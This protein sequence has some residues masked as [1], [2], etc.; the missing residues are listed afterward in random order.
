[1]AGAY[2]GWSPA[3]GGGV[4]GKSFPVAPAATV[5]ANAASGNGS[6]TIT[7]PNGPS[8]TSLPSF[9]NS[10]TAKV[11]Q[12]L[13]PV[14][15][16]FVP[17]SGTVTVSNRRW[18]ISTD[19]ITFTDITPL[20][21][22]QYTIAASDAGKYLR[23]AEDATDS[24]YGITFG[25]P[26]SLRVTGV[27]AFTA[28]SLTGSA[29]N[30]IV[31]ST[32][33][34]YS[35][36][37]SGY[38]NTFS[39]SAGSLPAGISLDPTTGALS[40][41]ATL[42]GTYNFKVK[43]TNDAGSDETAN[44]T[45]IVGKSPV[46]TSDDS[47]LQ[48]VNRVTNPI[49]VGTAI[50]D[51][52]FTT[53]AYPAATY[54]LKVDNATIPPCQTFALTCASSF[55]T[56]GLPDGLTFDPASATLKGTPTKTGAFVFAIKANN[57]LGSDIEIVHMSIASKAPVAFNL[58]SDKNAV[59]IIQNTTVTAT[60]TAT[61]GS[62]NG[63]Y[64]FFV[65]PT[66][67]AICS[68][69]ASTGNTVT[70]TVLAAGNCVING[71]KAADG[72]FAAAKASITI[73]VNKA[74][75]TSPIAVVADTAPLTFGGGSTWVRATGG[76]GTGAFNWNVDA[77]ST[78]SCGIQGLSGN[79]MLV[80]FTSAGTCVYTVTKAADGFFQA[81]TTQYTI[82]IDKA[83]ITGLYVGNPGASNWNAA[84]PPSV[85][86]ATG[87][88]QGTGAV[89][90]TLDPASAEICTLT[91]NVLQAKSA[92]SCNVSATKAGDINYK[93]MTS[94]SV[95][96]TIYQIAQ[97][98]LTT[99]G[100]STGGTSIAYNSNVPYVAS[101][102]VLVVLTTT[103]GSGT[104][105]YSYTASNASGCVVSGNGAT[106]F[107]TANP[108]GAGVGWCTITV[109]KNGDTNYNPQ[110]TNFQF[111]IPTGPQTPLVATPA[112]TSLDYVPTTLSDPATAAKSQISLTGGLG[113]GAVSYSVAAGSTSVCSV[114]ANGLITD[115]T[116]GTCVINISKAG[117]TNY[118]AQST[119]ATVT[120]NKLNQA[121][122]I[123]T[124]PDSSKPFVWS[125]KA[126]SQITTT[127]GAGTAGQGNN[128]G[129]GS[130]T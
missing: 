126:T 46:F 89:T 96:W 72:G 31:N 20:V 91:G 108:T 1:G 80:G 125:P 95:T 124:S 34:G 93:P 127:G 57:S 81:Q 129:N 25:S 62:G 52:T 116:A 90:Y 11:G 7:W 88:G 107:V 65:D 120:F 39:I 109:T 18:Q 16:I 71:V 74:L 48:S 32:Y 67:T 29:A 38:R 19:G 68:L 35:F 117:D 106:A 50:P 104:G 24:T 28:A 92:G 130:G 101:P 114:D 63:A 33:A 73:P 9:T 118:Q 98:A 78:A 42:T 61:G 70:M 86:L 21:S 110:S 12:V 2:D 41:T 43:V 99:T 84:N 112:S 121:E 5:T 49:R 83:Q 77:S 14:D 4:T 8:A 105:S 17:T 45:L 113:T 122:L 85:S 66:A 22:G 23:F 123:A 60:I 102:A 40:G 6:V 64:S 55:E 36:E 44:L 51:F 111:Y 69:S 103:G 100:A 54:E 58:S 15:G 79:A 53:Y 47:Q 56:L 87:G 94:A 30:T 76:N 13:T 26:A 119:T 37:S 75:Q 59:T 10:A 27:P 97:G 128:G 82:T 3:A 115:K